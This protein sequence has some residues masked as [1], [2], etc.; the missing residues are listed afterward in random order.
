MRMTQW[1]GLTEQAEKYLQNVGV[2]IPDVVCPKCHHVLSQKLKKEVYDKAR[3]MFGEE[4]P[5][6]KY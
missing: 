2:K 3:G 5:L 6:Y 1:I 4:I